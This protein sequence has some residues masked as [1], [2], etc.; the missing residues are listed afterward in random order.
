MTTSKSRTISRPSITGAAEDL[1]REMI[2]DKTLAPG[3]RLNE[4]A[5]AELAGISRGPVREAI[6]RLA[7]QG[8]LTTE[9]HRGAFVKSWEPQEIVDLYELR[10]AL[11][12]YAIRLTVDRASDEALEK[13]A[14]VL[15][16][17]IDCVAQVPTSEASATPYASEID[18]HQQL[19]ALSENRAIQDQLADANHKLYLALRPTSRTVSRIQHAIE[20]H[21]RILTAVRQRD[22]DASVELLS[23]HL[24]DSMTNSLEV[25]GFDPTHAPGGKSEK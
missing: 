1:I 10:S 22:A 21:Q 17:E 4:V 18:F 6:K 12:L 16:E 19:V 13:L 9:T 5:I 7:G 14:T 8:Y 20:A 2:L 11:E 23:E 3:E 25:L 24:L 15:D